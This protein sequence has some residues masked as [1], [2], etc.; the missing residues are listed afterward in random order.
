[1][2]TRAQARVAITGS[3]A[4]TARQRHPPRAPR[5]ESF[6]AFPSSVRTRFSSPFGLS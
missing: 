6:E 2:T 1:M 5:F 3:E 4:A